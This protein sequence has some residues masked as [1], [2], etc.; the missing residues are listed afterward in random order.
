MQAAG[1]G[2]NG[3]EGGGDERKQKRNWSAIEK[4]R[5]AVYR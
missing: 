4:K 2:S 3:Q 1:S 5:R